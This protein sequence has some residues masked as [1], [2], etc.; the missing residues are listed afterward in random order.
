[1]LG[2]LTVKLGNSFCQLMSVLSGGTAR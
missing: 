1:L 2:I